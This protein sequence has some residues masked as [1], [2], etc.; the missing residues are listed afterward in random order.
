M[1]NNPNKYP[2]NEQEKKDMKE[3]HCVDKCPKQ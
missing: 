2:E 1:G 3:P